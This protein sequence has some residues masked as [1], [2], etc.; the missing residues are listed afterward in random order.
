MRVNARYLLLTTATLVALV[1]CRDPSSSPSTGP[2]PL[3]PSPSPAP[4][5]PPVVLPGPG[6]TLSGRILEVAPDG[7][8]RPISARQVHV[9]VDVSEVTDPNRGGWVPVGA[10]GR[11]RLS[12]VLD[13]RFVKITSVDTS[14]LRS[15]YRFCG[16]NTTTRGDTELD[17]PLFL[18]GAAVPAPT[19]SG[20]V[21]TMID[22]NPVPLAG[23]DVYY[24]SRGYG[25]DVWEYT[26]SEGRYSLC[27][28]PALPGTLS[29]FCGNDIQVYNQTVDI[30]ANHV[31][32]IDATTFYTCLALVRPITATAVFSSQ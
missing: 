12:G 5:P 3:A 22:G 14:G 28:I 21:F 6:V 13:G 17:V 20:Q 31:I 30:R 18:P 16:T 7:T 25:S 9:E 24:V 4:Q 8:R 11:Y 2:N 26:D 32:D 19:L 15:R 1:S 27:G 29:M 23:A 10:D